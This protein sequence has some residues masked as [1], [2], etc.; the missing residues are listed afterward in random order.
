L[1]VKR[2]IADPTKCLACRACELACALAHADSDDLPEAIFEQGANPRI[3]IESSGGLAVPLQC[4]HC[5]DAP[6]VRVCPSGA[7]LRP[8]E[9]EPV[10]VDQQKCIGCAYCVQ[11]CPFGVIRLADQGSAIIKCDLCIE[12]QSEGLQPAC[13]VACPVAALS[14]EEVDEN[15]KRARARIAAQAA[16]V[17]ST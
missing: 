3:Y 17:H 12:R 16:A 8:S 15:A 6:C 9:A 11:T 7:L 4:R 14:L 5:E 1:I 13:V 10:L 2:I